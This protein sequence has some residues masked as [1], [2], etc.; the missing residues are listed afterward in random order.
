MGSSDAADAALWRVVV[1]YA[2]LRSRVKDLTGIRLRG[3]GRL[4]RL[5]RGERT[6][7]LAG[8]RYWFDPRVAVSYDLL[9]GGCFNEPETHAFL[10]YVLDRSHE[11]VTFIDVG[12]NVGEFLIS[13]AAHP[14]V[15]EAVGFEPHP[16]CA[17]V[18]EKSA[19]LNGFAHVRVE[20][21]LVGDGEV[22][23]FLMDEEAPNV[24]AIDASGAAVRTVRLDDLARDGDAPMIVLI[25]V[26]GAEP[27]VLRGAERLLQR[28]RPLVVF[29]YNNV[30]RT[31]YRLEEVRAQLGAGYVIHRLRSDARLDADVEASWNC[32]AVP[33]GTAFADICAPLVES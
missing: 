4:L 28:F 18:C 8:Q 31:R 23:R 24:S 5:V 29:E 1:G 11:A 6:F 3:L 32:V 26:E 14:R 15:V 30:S 33:S 9:V 2:K 17:A 27:L 13:V 25:D 16:D 21:A 12:A 20:R 7:T 10:T 22:H 19:L